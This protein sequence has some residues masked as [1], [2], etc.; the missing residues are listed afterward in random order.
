MAIE[1]IDR[2]KPKNG[3][4]F[5]MVDAED[6]DCGGVRLDAVLNRTVTLTAEMDDGSVQTYALLARA[7]ADGD[8]A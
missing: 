5:A 8:D 7:G 6:V 2:I 4:S 1:L 3:G